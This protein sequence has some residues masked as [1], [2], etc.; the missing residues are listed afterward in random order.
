MRPITDLHDD[1]NQ[2]RFCTK[3]YS[4][5]WTRTG[6]LIY[7]GISPIA[8]LVCLFDICERYMCFDKLICVGNVRTI[9]GVPKIVSN[10]RFVWSVVFIAP[11]SIIIAPNFTIILITPSAF[12]RPTFIFAILAVTLLFLAGSV[13]KYLVLFFLA[14]LDVVTLVI[15]HCDGVDPQSSR[16]RAMIVK[17]CGPKACCNSL[18]HGTL[19]GTLRA[20]D[21]DYPPFS[22]PY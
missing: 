13:V 20:W 16:R 1:R 22:L 17:L 11:S 14:S 19:S 15:L 18:S 5:Q 12:I 10:N 7:A 2:V 6:D 3:L 8:F 21:W 4:L 9:K